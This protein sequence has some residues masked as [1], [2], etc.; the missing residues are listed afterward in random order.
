MF[1][2]LQ[3]LRHASRAA[4]A[5]GAAF[6]AVT[7]GSGAVIAQSPP[8]PPARFVGTVTLNGQPAPAG[9]A[10]EARVGATSCGASTVFVQGGQSRY[11]IDVA[12]AASQPGCG[13]PDA[14][15][16]FVVGGVPA[17][18]TGSWR[19]YELNQLDLTA[20]SAA[21]TASPAVSPTVTATPRPPSAGSGQAVDGGVSGLWLASAAL[22]ASLAFVGMGWAA[23]RR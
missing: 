9:T 21:P 20:R 6:A 12:G 16:T 14:A 1:Q 8:E 15:V 7:L 4:L 5:A 10:V 23:A 13:T 3:P 11:T 19:N 2:Y 22:L 18:Q 17:A